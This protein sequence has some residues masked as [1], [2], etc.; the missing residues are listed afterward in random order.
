MLNVYRAIQLL[1]GSRGALV[2]V[3]AVPVDPQN[4]NLSM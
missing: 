3:V 2:H 1:F 4:V